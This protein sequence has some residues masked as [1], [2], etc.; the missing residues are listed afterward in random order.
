[1]AHYDSGGGTERNHRRAE[2]RSEPSEEAMPLYV[3]RADQD[4]L[5]HEE[6]D[7]AEERRTVKPQN[8][9]PRDGGAKEVLVD[10][11][12]EAPEHN[13]LEQQRHREIEVLID[14]SPRPR[15]GSHRARRDGLRK[16]SHLVRQ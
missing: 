4:G 8:E 6:D 16:R 14:E 11:A 2:R 13:C 9:R 15:E 7:P 5:K 12:A 1:M 10:C 3:S